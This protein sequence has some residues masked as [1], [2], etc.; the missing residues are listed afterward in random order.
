[1]SLAML[2]A[3]D[4]EVARALRRVGVE[5]GIDP[6]HCALIA[7]GGGGPLHAC[8]LADRLEIGRVIVP[9]AAGVLSALGLAV[10]PARREALSS[11]MTLASELDSP[12]VNALIARLADATGTSATAATWLRTRYRG[13]G[14]ELE[15]AVASGM[16]GAAVGV[17]FVDLHQARFGFTLDLPVEVIS[18]RHA[19]SGAGRSVRLTG[20]S[21]DRIIEGPS[22]IALPDATLLVPAGWRARALP[23]GGFEVT[24]A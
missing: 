5:R 23:I 16:D 19:A 17:R 8:R 22:S 7:F 2:A 4:A 14:H 3:A 18:A 24:R 20:E 6:R 11:V 13:Q 15:V 9:P 12:S 21:A 10:A 1:M